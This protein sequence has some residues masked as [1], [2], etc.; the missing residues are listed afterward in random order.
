[1]TDAFQCPECGR[2]G[3]PPADDDVRCPVCAE[4]AEFVE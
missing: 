3:D 4:A 1:M 2:T